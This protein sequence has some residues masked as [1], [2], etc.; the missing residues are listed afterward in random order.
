MNKNIVKHEILTRNPPTPAPKSPLFISSLAKALR[1]LYAFGGDQPRLTATEIARASG[2]DASSAQRFIFSLTAL[3]LLEKDARTKQYRLSVQLLDFAYLFLRAHP[4]SAVAFSHLEQ[5]AHGTGEHMNLS[6]LDRGD[7]IYVVRVPGTE[8]REQPGLVG[9]R[10][11]SFC[12]SNGR[13]LLAALPVEEARAI[14]EQTDR[15]P[16]TGKTITAPAAIM[17]KIQEARTQGYAIVDEE[18]E[19]GLLNL[20]VAVFGAGHRAIAAIN[21]PLPKRKWT[22]NDAV[23]RLLPEMNRTAQS[24]GRALL[25]TDL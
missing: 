17:N 4:L 19:K 13:V 21:C 3:G 24:L 2:L 10:M 14:V 20:A 12:T 18:S 15:R 23:K 5:L 22:V 11:P 7:V 1:V 16:L 25:G 8:R 9:G 6:I